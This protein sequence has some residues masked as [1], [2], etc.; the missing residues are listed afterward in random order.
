MGN[1]F[2]QTRI[3]NISPT[4]LRVFYEMAIVEVWK[5]TDVTSF[6][7]AFLSQKQRK[8]KKILNKIIM[9]KKGEKT[10]KNDPQ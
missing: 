9:K 6:L 7:G 5:V 4:K 3:F 2:H 1:F 10:I 8:R